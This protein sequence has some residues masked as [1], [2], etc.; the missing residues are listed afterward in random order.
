VSDPVRPADLVARTWAGIDVHIHVIDKPLNVRTIRR[1]VE[2]ATKIGVGT[3]FIVDLRLLPK[4]GERV[5]HDQ[6]YMAI[7]ALLGRLYAYYQA[8]NGPAIGEMTFAPVGRTTEIEALY[9]VKVQLNQ[10][11]SFRNSVKPN[12]MKGYWMVADFGV[13]SSKKSEDYARMHR[14]YAQTSNPGNHAHG[15]SQQE[16]TSK[17]SVPPAGPPVAKTKLD[18]CYETLGIHRS[19]TREEVKAAFRKLAFELHPDVSELPKAEAELRF[20]VL[21]EAYEFIKTTQGW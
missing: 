12:I 14:Q 13:D 5:S 8:S 7:H 19:A 2:S 18:T 15:S 1:I 6:W 4:Q 11:R 16:Y 10:L 17:Q 3:L 9:G 21:S 20:K